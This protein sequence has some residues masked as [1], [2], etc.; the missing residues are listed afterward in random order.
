MKYFTK[1]LAAGALL[2]PLIGCGGG[3][4][5]KVGSIVGTWRTTGIGKVG[6]SGGALVSCPGFIVVDGERIDCDTQPQYF[7]ADGFF[8]GYFEEDGRIGRTTGT[9]THVDDE[10]EVTVT[11]TAIDADGSGTFSG[12]ETEE[13]IVP[14]TYTLKVGRVDTDTIGVTFD[15]GDVRYVFVMSRSGE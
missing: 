11:E 7:G 1:W 2:L 5:S 13:L 6:D 10:I 15:N 8:L 4:G 14:L 3:G 12:D 9:Y